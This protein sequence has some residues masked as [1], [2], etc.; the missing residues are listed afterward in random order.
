MYNIQEV[1][2]FLAHMLKKMQKQQKKPIIL[3]VYF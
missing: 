1:Y 2:F 3:R